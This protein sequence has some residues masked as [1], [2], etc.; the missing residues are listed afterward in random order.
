MVDTGIALL[1]FGQ[2]MLLKQKRKQE[3]DLFWQLCSAP[4][5]FFEV[6]RYPRPAYL[7][8]KILSKPITPMF[9]FSIDFSVYFSSAYSVPFIILL[10][11]ASQTEFQLNSATL[12]VYL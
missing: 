8:F 12:I 10:F 4:H 11:A 3:F 2:P 1:G 5:G 7:I 9:G 6:M